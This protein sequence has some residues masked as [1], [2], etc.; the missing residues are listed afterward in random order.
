MRAVSKNKP[1]PYKKHQSYWSE[2][3]TDTGGWLAKFSYIFMPS[4]EN[5]KKNTATKKM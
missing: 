3:A 1:K 4:K 2:C 5:N